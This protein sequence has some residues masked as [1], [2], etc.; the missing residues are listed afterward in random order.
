MYHT[1]IMT[2]GVSLFGFA[3]IFGKFCR[4]D[5]P[6]F[7][8][9]RQNPVLTEKIEEQEAIHLFVSKMKEIVNQTKE[10]P[11]N[12]SAEYSLIH[13][14]KELNKLGNHL[15]IVLFHTNTLGGKAAAYLLKEVL[16]QDFPCQIMLKEI[17]DFDVNNR[18][19]LNIAL[20]KYLR[21]LSDELV[22]HHPDYTCFAPLGGYK[23][24]TSFG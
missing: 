19:Q 16:E 17:S 13:R 5:F 11:M 18:R 7:Q 21:S 1:V 20:G 12:V 4:S 22:E 8:F 10:N 23:V 24:M 15:H 3:N 9:E 14:L 6:L 2:S